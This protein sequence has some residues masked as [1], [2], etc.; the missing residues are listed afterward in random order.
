[1]AIAMRARI[2][3]ST[4]PTHNM[5]VC[6][7]EEGGGDTLPPSVSKLKAKIINEKL[8]TEEV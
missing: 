4:W 1:M 5:A 6:D 3:E 8:I 7:T 2:L